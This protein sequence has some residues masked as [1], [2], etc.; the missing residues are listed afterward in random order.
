TY[1]KHGIEATPD[2]PM[3][4]KITDA[5]RDKDLKTM[6]GMIGHNSLN[7]ASEEVFS[8]ITGIKMGKTQSARVAQLLEWAGPEKAQAL[9]ES[10]ALAERERKARGL[11]DGLVSAWADL[12]GLRV[13][14]GGQVVNGQEY[15]TLKVAGGQDRIASGKEGAATTYH[16]VNDRGE[17]SRV[18][19][20]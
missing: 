9:R 15:V 1:W 3:I 12:K 7:P 10:N 18:K 16:L 14:V 20:V 4:G 19:D 11:R 17:Y 5:I 2:S 6:M 8:R 13:D